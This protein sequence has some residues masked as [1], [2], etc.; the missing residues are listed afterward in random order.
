MDTPNWWQE[1]EMIPD[2]DDIQELA[3]KIRAYF[4]LPQ[5]TSEIHGIE[6]YY[7]AL[8]APHCLCGKDFLSLPD[9]RFPCPDLWEEQQKKTMAY[10]QALQCW[11]KRAN[12]PVPGQPC[13]LVGSVLELHKMMEHYISF[14]DD[15]IFSSVA[16]PE[17][18]FGSQTSV[19]RDVLPT[20]TD[21]PTKDAAAPIRGPLEESTPPWVPHEKWVRME[22]PPN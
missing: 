12:L 3:Q 18:F 13:L 7:L 20:F 6:N 22:A 19:S 15:N 8:P 10:A 21:V 1:L 14:S 11:A 16:L 4:K 17:R 5:W 9:P 2:V